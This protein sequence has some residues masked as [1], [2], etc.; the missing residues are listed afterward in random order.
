[1]SYLCFSSSMIPLLP[2]IPLHTH[3]CTDI[4]NETP[5]SSLQIPPTDQLHN[6]HGFL[7]ILISKRMKKN[8]TNKNRER[9]RKKKKKTKIEKG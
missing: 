8:K 5:L 1:M 7:R 4:S 9:N 3:T 6:Q 2:P